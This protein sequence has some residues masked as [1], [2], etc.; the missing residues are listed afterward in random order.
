MASFSLSIAMEM[1]LKTCNKDILSR[2]FIKQNLDLL[3]G[4]QDI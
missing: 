2:H 4:K 1:W 3:K